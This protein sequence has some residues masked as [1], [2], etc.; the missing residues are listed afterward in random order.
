MIFEIP[1]SSQSSLSNMNADH[2]RDNNDPTNATFPSIN[3][4]N[5]RC[6]LHHSTTNKKTRHNKNQNYDHHYGN[7]HSFLDY[8]LLFIE[9]ILNLF[10]S[11]SSTIQRHHHVRYHP[12]NRISSV[13]ANKPLKSYAF[14]QYYFLVPG[15]IR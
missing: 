2:C 3:H 12:F 14:L 4:H 11:S 5:H 8:T 6:L 9:R 13:V 1:S 7:M 15:S 10:S